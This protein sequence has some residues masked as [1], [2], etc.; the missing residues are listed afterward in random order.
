MT[1]RMLLKL[2]VLGALTAGLAACGGSSNNGVADVVPTPAPDSF[3]VAVNAVIATTSETGDPR[4]VDSI[5]ATSP[6]NTEPSGV[7]S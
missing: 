7:G 5:V 6:E 4:E 1:H 2:A 3:F